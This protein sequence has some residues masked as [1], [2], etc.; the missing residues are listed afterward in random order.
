ML[1]L[2]DVSLSLGGVT[3][4]DRVNL[5][6]GP[7]E[8]VVVHGPRGAGKSVLLSIAAARRPPDQ[9]LVCIAGRKIA[10]LQRTSLPL[11]HRRVAY[12]PAVAPLFDD[13]SAIEN[14]ML[15]PA[16]RGD[17]VDTCWEAARKAL[18]L[19]GI[20]ACAHRR[21]GALSSG[22]RR[23]CAVARALAGPP[24]ALVL[25]DPTAGLCPADRDRVLAALAT[26]AGQGTAVLLA[27]NDEMLAQATTAR[28]GRRVRLD[29]GRLSGGLPGIAL[30]PRLAGEPDLL[31]LVREP[32]A[33]S[34]P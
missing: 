21:V 26:V 5:A 16:V 30:V 4:L 8:L 25:D 23:L 15:A 3:R 32:R 12:L 20:D 18:E 11:V 19:T 28:G 7:G 31:S 9:G 14:V 17:G 13:E 29:G 33:R 10:D 6:V 27:T 2:E 22:E 24:P 34:S 1:R